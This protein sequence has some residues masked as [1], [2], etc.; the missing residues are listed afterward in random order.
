[1][2]VA[3]VFRKRVAGEDGRGGRSRGKTGGREL[4]IEEKVVSQRAEVLASGTIN[5]Q[6][7]TGVR[8]G[9]NKFNA[10]INR[11]FVFDAGGPRV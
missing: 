5:K 9:L 4:V 11:S 7:S 1:M 3:F 6:W 8:S 10:S 2:V